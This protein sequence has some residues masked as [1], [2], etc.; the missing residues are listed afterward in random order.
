L[1]ASRASALSDYVQV[2]RRDAWIIAL[3]TGLI[4]LI[5][6]VF[7]LFQDDRYSSHSDVFL[8]GVSTIPGDFGY[9]Q[10]RDID[11]ERAGNTQARLARIP[12][13]ASLALREARL[14]DRSPQDVLDNVTV[15]QPPDT[16]ILRFTVEDGSAATAE[17]LATAYATAFTRYRN[18]QDL[19]SLTG[20]R[21]KTEQRLRGIG[22]RDALYPGLTQQYNQLRTAEVLLNS[23]ATVVRRGTDAVQVQP[24]PIR[25]GILGGL[26]G[27][28]LGVGLVVVREGLNTRVR[29]PEEVEQTLGLPLIGRVPRPRRHGGAGLAM[30]DSPDAPETEAYRMIATNLGFVNLD[31]GAKSVMVTSAADGEGKS[32][33][34]ANLAIAMARAG[35][36]VALID[37]DLKRPSLDGLFGLDLA[38]FGVGVTGVALG[39]ISL[40]DA[41]IR[42]P[43]SDVDPA[44]SLDVLLTGQVPP[45]SAQFIASHRVTDLLSTLS[46]RYDIVLIDAAP[47]AQASDAVALA[48]KVDAVIV[49]AGLS[50]VRRGSLEELRRILDSTP[51]T[52]LGFVLTG[53]PMDDAYR[54]MYP[55][56]HTNG[57]GFQGR[58]RQAGH[59]RH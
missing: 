34:V 36:R 42:I 30:L 50:H 55:P 57:S 54:H 35:S 5:A 37:F 38:Q 56:M 26:L 18:Q 40:D 24:K 39:Q 21:R 31:R 1:K 48:G 2:L 9:E 22:R 58:R 17:R 4:A 14:T 13:V 20:A 3:T 23:T 32:T 46:G 43:V 49:V 59:V 44:G 16:D 25:N 28:L 33:T 45:D 7:S 51:V 8:S 47:M 12:T 27:L 15:S 11:P 19:A 29:D 10:Q 6:V 52:K 53:V 41:L